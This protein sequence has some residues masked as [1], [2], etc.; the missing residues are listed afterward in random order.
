MRGDYSRLSKTWWLII[1]KGCHKNLQGVKNTQSTNIRRANRC[2]RFCGKVPQHNAVG[3]GVSSL[4]LVLLA[5]VLLF[6]VGLLSLL[7]LLLVVVVVV[8][9]LAVVAARPATPQNI[10]HLVLR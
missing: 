9:L 8:V 7:L 6:V 4:L 5:V 2:A 10:N 1:F 3:V